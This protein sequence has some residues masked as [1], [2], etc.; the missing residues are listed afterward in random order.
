MVR[1]ALRSL[2]KSGHPRALALTGFHVEADV[3]MKSFRL[4]ARRV[5]IG[6]SITLSLVLRNKARQAVR[7]CV[8]YA[9]HYAAARGVPRRKVFKGAD[10]QLQP[11]QTQA[12]TFVR[13]FQPRTTRKLY[14]GRHVVEVLA[15]GAA[16]SSIAF[17]LVQGGRRAP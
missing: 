4:S 14:P 17:D 7:V 13:D 8:D 12:L 11:G 1:H 2:V 5:H 10:L 6:E 16:L 9:V 15:N 3:E